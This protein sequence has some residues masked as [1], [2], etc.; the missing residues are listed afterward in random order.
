METVQI[1]RSRR[2]TISLQIKPDAS[3]VV[4]A[5]MRMPQ[6]EI[7]KFL[8]EKSGWIETH[9]AK[10]RSQQAQAQDNL[11][12]QEDL[13]SLAE[14]AKALIPGRAAYYAARM[15]VTFGRITIRHQTT[16][17]GSCSSK[18]NLNFNCLLMLAPPEVLDYVVVHELAHRKQMN[19]SAAFWAEVEKACPDYRVHLKWLKDNGGTLMHRANGS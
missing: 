18:G 12:T 19:H 5:P 17:W 16:R 15:G 2:K 1:I 11:L 8:E 13:R 3:I 6:R 9:L 10:V 14:Q 4:R 7:Q